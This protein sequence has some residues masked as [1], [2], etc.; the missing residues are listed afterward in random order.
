MRRFFISTLAA[1]TMFIFGN[2]AQAQSTEVTLGGETYEAKLV[3]TE[4]MV[5]NDA[6]YSRGRLGYYVFI[7]SAHTDGAIDVQAIENAMDC[8][9]VRPRFGLTKPTNGYFKFPAYVVY[10]GPYANL[11]YC[12]QD[13]YISAGVIQRF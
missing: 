12:V 9:S 10:Y 5:S 3:I 1:A 8:T 2:A 4:K 13:E 7:A 6:E 11:G